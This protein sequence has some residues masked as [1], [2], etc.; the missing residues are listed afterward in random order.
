[1]KIL[2]RVWHKIDALG[3]R[4]WAHAFRLTGWKGFLAG[5]GWGRPVLLS[6]DEL[7]AIAL[8]LRLHPGPFLIFGAGHDSVLW[9]ILNGG[10][11]TVFLESD[12]YWMKRIGARARFLD[13]YQVTY[14]T[15]L[16]EMRVP[17]IKELTPPALDLP[18]TLRVQTWVTILVDAPQGWGDGPGRL[19]SIFEAGRLVAKGGRIFVHDCDREGERYLTGLYLREFQCHKINPRL[20]VFQKP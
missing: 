1:M 9:A 17:E 7:F 20:W 15:R 18:E 10:R 8:S 4:A 12:P 3:Q 14:T 11:S 19:Q 6:I 5:Y 13:L 16:D 2:L